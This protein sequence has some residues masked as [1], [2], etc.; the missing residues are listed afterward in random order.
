MDELKK[1]IKEEREE[2]EI[3]LEEVLKRYNGEFTGRGPQE[4]DH[5]TGGSH[6][7]VEEA[8]PNY[9][10]Y[11]QLG[12][13]FQA[14]FSSLQIFGWVFVILTILLLPAFYYYAQAGG[15]QQVTHGYYNSVFMLG[16]MGFNKAVC[17]SSYVQLYNP[18]LQARQTE[19]TCEVGTMTNITYAGIIP[20]G[21]DYTWENVAYGYCNDWNNTV[22]TNSPDQV[23]PGTKEC[24]LNYL[25][26]DELYSN[27]GL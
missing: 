24:S 10:P 2:H 16:N 23:P 9:D 4:Y 22:G 12:Y 27:F 5:T 14:Y 13:G 8:D 3:K 19:M 17:F 1:I 20:A 21:I 18:D 11:N 6:T 15:L 26:Y 25:R 7:R